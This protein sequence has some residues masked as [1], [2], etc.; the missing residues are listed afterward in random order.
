MLG[1]EEKTE[2]L[3]GSGSPGISSHGKPVLGAYSG[4]RGGIRTREVRL[5][6]KDG[7]PA[8]CLDS[9]RAVWDTAGKVIRYQ[10]TLV[11]ITEK[12]K[13]ERQLRSKRNSAGGCWKAF[14]T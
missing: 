3:A 9:S 5:T 10:G 14:P 11:D 12:R 2:L 8:V 4:D 7:T 6:R 1:Y 13:M